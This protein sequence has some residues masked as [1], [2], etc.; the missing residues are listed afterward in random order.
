MIDHR[1]R[2]PRAADTSRRS[3]RGGARAN[4]DEVIEVHALSRAQ[5]CVAKAED[6]ERDTKN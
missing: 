4:H 1:D 3:L 5:T 2:A 6:D